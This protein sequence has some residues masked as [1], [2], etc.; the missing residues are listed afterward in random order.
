MVPPKDLGSH[1]LICTIMLMGH[2]SEIDGMGL[3]AGGGSSF[4]FRV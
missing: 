3:R 1:C 2:T 4:E